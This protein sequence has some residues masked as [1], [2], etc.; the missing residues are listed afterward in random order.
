M[1]KGVLMKPVTLTAIAVGL[2]FPL[3]FAQLAPP[4]PAAARSVSV[5]ATGTAYGEPDEASFDAGVSALNADVQ[6]ATAQVGDRAEALT[7]ALLAAGVA[8]NDVRTSSFTISPEQSYDNNGQPTT[9]R[10]RV[11]NTLHV[12]VRDV[13]QLGALL[14]QSVEAGANEVGSVVYTFSD[15][16][17]LERQARE[18]AMRSAQEKAQQLAEYGGAQLG[19]V[20]RISEG[21]QPGAPMPLAEY[22]MDAANAMAASPEVPVSSGQL[23]VTVLVQVTYG[24]R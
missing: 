16:R 17:A 6:V 14:G 24:L 7:Q 1:T 4:Q 2:L 13:A 11:A 22:R 3:A 10:Y 21:A 20:Q 18:Q 19:A 8:E 15:Q 5:S 12:T 23:A 9:L